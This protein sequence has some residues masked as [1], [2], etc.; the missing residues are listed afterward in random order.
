MIQINLFTKQKEAHR[1]REQIYGCQR[2]KGRGINC[3]FGIDGYIL[4][5]IQNRYTIRTYV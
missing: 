1:H 4:L 5:H 3:E 2:G